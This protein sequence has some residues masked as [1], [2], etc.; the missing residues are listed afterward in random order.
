MVPA[1]D[2]RA[3]AMKMAT[4]LAGKAPIAVRYILEA[5][6]HGAEMPLVEAQHLEATFFG[7]IASTEDMKEGTR[8]FLEKRPADW[9][10][11]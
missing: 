10:G 1:A 6:H 7:L 3:E 11:R 4:T 9:K 2:L 5:V 8:A